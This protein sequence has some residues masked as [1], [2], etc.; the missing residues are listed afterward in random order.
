MFALKQHIASTQIVLLIC[1]AFAV[2]THTYDLHIKFDVW[3][4]FCDLERFWI[5]IN[6]N[7]LSQIVKH[8]NYY[9]DLF[10]SHFKLCHTKYRLQRR[11]WEWNLEEEGNENIN[12]IC[13]WCEGRR[14]VWGHGQ[15]PVDNSE[16]TQARAEVKTENLKTPK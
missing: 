16:Y 8:L 15:Y 7:N 11:Q 10:N 6:G 12:S 13:D 5:L 1:Y 4:Y 2:H 3:C 14:K 9:L